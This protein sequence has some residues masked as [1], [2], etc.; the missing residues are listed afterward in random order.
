MG[1]VRH[2]SSSEQPHRPGMKASVR[3]NQDTDPGR[4]NLHLR[5]PCWPGAT[6]ARN[7]PLVFQQ[8]SD[9]LQCAGHWDRVAY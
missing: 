9:Y 2:M 5:G 6:L 1:L 4:G 8:I 7:I 3:H